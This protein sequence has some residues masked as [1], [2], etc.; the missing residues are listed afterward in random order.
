[1]IFNGFLPAVKRVKRIYRQTA[2]NCFLKFSYE[3]LGSE[4]VATMTTPGLKIGFAHDAKTICGCKSRQ[5]TKNQAIQS[6]FHSL[7]LMNTSYT[8]SIFII[9]VV[10]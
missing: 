8:R 9:D 7:I 10:I 2:R 4:E 3:D 5:K 1:M 6:G